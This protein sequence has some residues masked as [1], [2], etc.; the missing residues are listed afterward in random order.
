MINYQEA[1]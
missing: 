1:T